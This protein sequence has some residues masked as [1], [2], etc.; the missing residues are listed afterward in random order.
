VG[1]VAHRDYLPE[2]GRLEPEAVVVAVAGA[3][4]ARARR[5]AERYGIPAWHVG[6]GSLL[7]DDSVDA[8]LNLTPPKRHEEVNAAAIEAG[9]PVYSE[10]PL[11]TTADAARALGRAAEGRGIVLS[12]AP[13]VA[14]F[15]QVRRAGEALAS[16]RLGRPVAASGSV[17]GG[18]PPWEGFASDPTPY[19]E[20]DVGPLVDLGV[21]PLHALTA[22][23]GPA[24]RV[25]ATS[26]RT[27]SSFEVV[28]GPAAGRTVRV[29]VDDVWTVTAEVGD[30]VV[31]TI[32]ANFAS[33]PGAEPEL[34][35]LC[36]RGAIAC[37][38]LD[39]SAPVR[40]SDGEAWTEI[41]VPAERASGPDHV[42]GV[43][44]FVR[45]VRGDESPLL[46]AAHAAH[47]LDAIEA[48]RRASAEGRAIDV[49]DAGWSPPPIVSA[50]EET[51]A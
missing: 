23:L 38:L 40:V 28:D 29:D 26:R 34:E 27:R 10:K 24:T 15:P 36:E 21:Y 1:D 47:V 51:R 8:V 16:G 22:L 13:S 4:E 20:A 31:A 3:H 42:L 19:F 32:H 46:T 12:A 9:R 25:S 39:P 35:I 6:Y 30:G 37:S 5:T 18:V 11:A 2:I 41:E 45:C 43:R 50:A 44:H 33:A 48:A 7:A 49:P 17:F 14:V